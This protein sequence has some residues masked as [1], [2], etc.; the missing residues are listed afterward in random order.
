VSKVRTPFTEEG[1]DKVNCYPVLKPDFQGIRCIEAFFQNQIAAQTCE[2][3]WYLI[4]LD[5]ITG[6]QY[7]PPHTAIRSVR[8]MGRCTVE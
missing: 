8:E 1:E 2:V 7:L 3:G 6:I 5:K 4:A